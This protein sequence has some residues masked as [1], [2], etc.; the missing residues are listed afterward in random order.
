M[1][2]DFFI[3]QENSNFLKTGRGRLFNKFTSG[4][5]FLFKE[6]TEFCGLYDI[7]TKNIEIFL[8]PHS[9]VDEIVDTIEHECLHHC[10]NYVDENFNCEKHI[11]Y[12][13][14]RL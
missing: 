3:N 7:Q 6:K 4:F 11:K 9:S 8:K 14:E 5:G 13:Q 12:I 2:I 1:N 10:L